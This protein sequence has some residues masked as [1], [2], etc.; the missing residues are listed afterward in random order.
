MVVSRK[1]KKR[2]I[3]V[4]LVADEGLGDKGVGVTKKKKSKV[5]SISKRA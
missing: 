1:S 5:I 3:K 4:K 2:K